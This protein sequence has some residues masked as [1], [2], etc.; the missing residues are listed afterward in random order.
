MGDGG[1]SKIKTAALPSRGSG[2]PGHS[3]TMEEEKGYEES[4]AKESCEGQ[5]RYW[6]AKVS[7]LVCELG[8]RESASEGSCN[9]VERGLSES[10]GSQG[11]GQ[12]RKTQ[13]HKVGK[14]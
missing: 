9:Q 12:M 7:N 3:F 4:A 2:I 8:N 14:N 1:V 5:K 6:E 10:G 13:G 11:Q